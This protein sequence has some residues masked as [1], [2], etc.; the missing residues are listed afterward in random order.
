MKEHK[1]TQKKWFFTKHVKDTQQQRDV[2]YKKFRM[3][4]AAANWADYKG[5]KK[6][7]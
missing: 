6:Q 2:A 3:T 4:K 5:K 7:Q 1:P